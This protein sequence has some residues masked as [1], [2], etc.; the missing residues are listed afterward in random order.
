[1]RERA[2]LYKPQV[3]KKEFTLSKRLHDEE[4]K[5]GEQIPAKPLPDKRFKGIDGKPMPPP[6]APRVPQPQNAMNE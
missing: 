4:V 1:M 2:K 3:N 5:E 6:N